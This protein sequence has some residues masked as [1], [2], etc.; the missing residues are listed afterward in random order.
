MFSVSQL[1]RLLFALTALAL[2]AA[3]V[4]WAEKP[5]KPE[6][7]PKDK[8]A[9]SETSAEAATTKG[10]APP[11]PPPVVFR[12]EPEV[13]LVPN[14]RV[15]Y[16]PDLKYD[17]FRYGRHWYINSGGHWYRARGYSGPY[18]YL[19]YG[20]VPSTILRLPDKYHRQPMRPAASS[21]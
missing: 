12:Q 5:D 20:R 11:A 13:I 16:V 15:Y 18:E 8:P 10:K 19:D 2:L 6:R 17:L 3:P 7:E 1:R 14:T 9:K 4:A 21:R